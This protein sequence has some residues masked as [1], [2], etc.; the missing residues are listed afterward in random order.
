MAIYSANRRRTMLILLLTSAL[1]ITLDLRGNAVFDAARSGFGYA[2]RPFETAGEVITRPVTRA[3]RGMTEYDDLRRENRA[4]REQ[5]DQQRGDLIAAQSALVENRE[6]AALAGLETLG[7][8][9]R[10]TARIIGSSPSNFDQRIEIDRGTLHG[11]RNGMVV[12]NAAGLVGKITH[13]GPTTSIVMLA[14]DPLY[15]VAVKVVGE[16]R[17]EPAPPPPSTSPSGIPIDD[18]TSTTTTTTSTLA[19]GPTFFPPLGLPTTTTVPPDGSAEATGDE[20][21]G[22][23]TGDAT[24]DGTFDP[25]TQTTTTTTTTTQPPRPVTRETGRLNGMGGDRLPR[26]SLIA[27]TPLFGLPTVGDVVLTAGGSKSLAPPDIPV[28]RVANV[29]RVGGSKGIELEVELS[30]DL[31]RLNF[32]TVLLYLPPSEVIGLDE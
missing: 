9:D 21:T 3:W 23:T 30:A 18:L 17:P 10:V 1:L 8:Y 14:T 5:L 27:D 19:P 22:E 24:G 28:G 7:D 2:M 15:N 31:D 20:A 16:E 26:V 13:A 4:L 11:L 12:L 29:I 6:L 32:L 25:P